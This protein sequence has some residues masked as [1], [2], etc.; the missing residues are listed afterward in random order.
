MFHLEETN[1]TSQIADVQNKLTQ[2]I[3]KISDQLDSLNAAISSLTLEQMNQ[4]T[5]V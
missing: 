5:E 1:Y 3:Q 2:D 4:K